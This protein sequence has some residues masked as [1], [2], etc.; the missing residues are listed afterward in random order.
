MCTWSYPK[1]G[2]APPTWV[3]PATPPPQ[4]PQT[5]DVVPQPT[6]HRCCSRLQCPPVAKSTRNLICTWE[7]SQEVFPRPVSVAQ[8]VVFDTPVGSFLQFNGASIKSTIPINNFVAKPSVSFY[9]ANPP[10][11]DEYCYSKAMAHALG[12]ARVSTGEQDARLQHDALTAAG[13]Y[14]IFTDT[15]SGALQSR[16]E[17]DKLMDQLRP[18][19]TLVVWRLDRLG[20]SI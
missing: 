7:R 12:Y 15:A 5:K 3:A 20:R 11:F 10:M 6:L 2:S 8:S 1:P 19:D 13:C 14:R 17:L 9:V 4:K 18:G 16:P